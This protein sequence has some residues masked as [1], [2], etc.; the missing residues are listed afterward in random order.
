MAENA[1]TEDQFD[2]DISY[3]L[4]FETNTDIMDACEGCDVAFIVS[5]SVSS[6]S[7]DCEDDNS[8]YA[9]GIHMNYDGYAGVPVLL[10]AG[11]DGNTITSPF[12]LWVVDG[13]YSEDGLGLTSIDYDS[14]TGSFSYS[15]G[16]MNNNNPYYYM[17][18][19]EFVPAD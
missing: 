15:T 2:C 9:F 5:T 8:F 3:D 1:E 19:T 6:H 11:T 16:Y 13:E 12:E 17:V 4:T 14:T 18:N 10:Y 7:G